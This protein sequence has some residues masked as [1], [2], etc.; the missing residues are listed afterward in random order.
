LTK[1]RSP[2]TRPL[3]VSILVS[4]LLLAACDGS[5]EPAR[6]SPTPT[7]A[8]SPTPT[9]ATSPTSTVPTSPTP[10]AAT[11]GSA[12]LVSGDEAYRHVVVLAQDIG[13]RAAGSDTE[14]AAADYIADQLTS[15]GFRA[16]IESFEVE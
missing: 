4:A 1:Y 9:V 6:T 12:S 3:L 2:F 14:F 13:S 5:A 8:T 15:Y 11:G 7:V 10:T 16:V